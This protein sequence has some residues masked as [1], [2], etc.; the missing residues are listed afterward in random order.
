MLLLRPVF[1]AVYFA[2]I[3]TSL[4]SNEGTY[5]IKESSAAPEG[6]TVLHRTPPHVRLEVNI[7]LKQSDPDLIV[8]H[9]YEGMTRKCLRI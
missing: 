7:A 5:V 1:A 6:W 2:C 9:L 3:S 4:Q 8:N